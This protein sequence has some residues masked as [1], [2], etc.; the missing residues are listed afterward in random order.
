MLIGEMPRVARTWPLARPDLDGFVLPGTRPVPCLLLHGFTSSPLEVRPLAE[1]LAAEGYAVR[2][3]RLPGHG[4][5]VEDLA[6]V[7][8][9][10]LLAAA[11]DTLRELIDGGA[12]AVAVAGQ[13]MGALLALVLAARHGERV[14]AVASLAAPVWFADRRARFLV[15]LLRWTPFYDRLVRFVP[16]GPSGIPEERRAQH[17]TYDCF[18]L[19]GVVGLGEL[20]RRAWSVLPEIK[21]PLLVAH[22]SLDPT[23]PPPGAARIAARAGSEH[24][25]HREFARSRHVLTMDVESDAVCGAVAEF[26]LRHAA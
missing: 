16:K 25:E 7:D 23:A 2:A 20:M 26:F 3:P 11:D 1:A 6:T 19:R 14:A 5:H 13:S 21:A 8:P 18:P 10:M 24:K 15:P 4:T 17:F 22:G 12:P 9:D